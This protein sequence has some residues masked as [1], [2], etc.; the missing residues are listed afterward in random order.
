M[1][2]VTIIG[3][4]IAGLA[5]ALRLLERGFHVTLLERHMFLGGKL[6][7]HQDRTGGDFHEHAYHMY[8]NWYHNFWRIADEIGVRDRFQPQHRMS[9]LR[10]G[11]GD[12]RSRMSHAADV[13]SIATAWYNVMNGP[14][15]PADM[16]LYAFSMVDLL[17]TPMP[18]TA[19]LDQMSVQGFLN[20][21]PYMTE[22][23]MSMQNDLLLKAFACPSYLTAADAFHRYVSFGYRNPTPMM[24]LLRGNTQEQLFAPLLRH[25]R[26]IA[27]DGTAQG[28]FDLRAL[29]KVTRLRL[30]DAGRVCA[31]EGNI[32]AEP[33]PGPSQSDPPTTGH[34]KVDVAGDA[35]LAIPPDQAKLLVHADVFARAPSLGNIASLHCQPMCSLDLYFKRPVDLPEGP[36]DLLDSRFKLSF[37]DTSRLWRG[38]D[39]GQPPFINVVASDSRAIYRYRPGTIRDLMLKELMLYL[40]ISPDDVDLPRSVVHPNATEELFINEVGSWDLRPATDCEIPNLFLAGDYC[41]NLIDVVTIEAAVVSG[42]LAAEAVRARAG[43]GSPVEIIAPKSASPWPLAGLKLA[44]Q[45]YAYAAQALSTAQRWW[46]GA[47][48]E[49]FPRG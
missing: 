11:A 32:L 28:R 44:G 41:R 39:D 43:V 18:R 20:T 9:Y 17:G 2:H 3:A 15:S 38:K 24:W 22:G 42:L 19:R 37:L 47:Y 45:P 23:A 4:G 6:A 46:T 14:M 40:P 48:R 25:I 27:D 36:V 29:H 21:R 16:Y 5:A 33:A 26:R 7:A 1:P 8:L 31:I 49:M 10:S 12:W 35:I 34:F 30:D 13:G